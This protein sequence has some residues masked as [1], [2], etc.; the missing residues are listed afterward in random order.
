MCLYRI[1]LA[2]GGESLRRIG[3]PETR[4]R[5]RETPPSKSEYL[6]PQFFTVLGL[7]P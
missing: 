2:G 1:P 6:N 3:I 7:L 5:A 4:Q